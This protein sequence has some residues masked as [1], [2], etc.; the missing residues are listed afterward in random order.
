MTEDEA[1]LLESLEDEAANSKITLSFLLQ[2]GDG[3]L[4]TAAVLR[5]LEL[6]DGSLVHLETRQPRPDKVRL[7]LGLELETNLRDVYESM[8]TKTYPPVP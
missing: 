1:E 2:L 4:G 7:G 5:C 6:E 8:L 3:C